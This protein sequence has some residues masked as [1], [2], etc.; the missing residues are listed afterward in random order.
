[1]DY[2]EVNGGCGVGQELGESR[3]EG[4]SLFI[5]CPPRRDRTTSFVCG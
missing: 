3:G 1:M 5:A 4:K 2:V